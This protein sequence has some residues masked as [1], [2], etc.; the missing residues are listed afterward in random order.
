[1][2]QYPP[3]SPLRLPYGKAAL[4]GLPSQRLQLLLVLRRFRHGN[5]HT[6]GI[7]KAA[8]APQNVLNVLAGDFMIFMVYLY[9]YFE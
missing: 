3:V 1:M 9:W 8:M 6:S 4:N 5:L 2:L 7:A